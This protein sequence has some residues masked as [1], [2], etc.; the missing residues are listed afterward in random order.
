M[1]NSTGTHRQ[2]GS[3]AT[4]RQPDSYGFEK[5]R[6]PG[7]QAIR[8]AVREASRSAEERALELIEA[9]SSVHRDRAVTTTT[10]TRESQESFMEA[11][12]RTYKRS[13]DEFQARCTAR[14]HEI[15]AYVQKQVAEIVAASK[16]KSM[17][18]AHRRECQI[19]LIMA[20][21]S[22]KPVET[23][24]GPASEQ[25]IKG[26]VLTQLHALGFSEANVTAEQVRHRVSDPGPTKCARIT[27]RVKWA[28]PSENKPSSEKEPEGNMVRDCAVCCE[29]LPMIV[30]VPCGHTLCGR[31]GTKLQA[32]PFCSMQV[33]RC[34]SVFLQ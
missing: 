5:H 7:Q 30:L 13:Q 28:S 11:L 19:E 2:L 20:V 12:Q 14:Q 32:C 21:R 4:E 34:Q 8:E 24:D 1:G 9:S 18:A 29:Q 33:Q 26:H 27:V 17:Y 10:T 23:A 25:I 16:T 22:M 6:Q 31:C 3:R 15:D